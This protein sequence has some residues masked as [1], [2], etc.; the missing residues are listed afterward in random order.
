MV[1]TCIENS[2]VQ[3]LFTSEQRTKQQPR[4]SAIAFIWLYLHIPE[5]PIGQQ[6]G[7]A[8]QAVYVKTY[9]GIGSPLRNG[10]TEE[11]RTEMK[12][13]KVRVKEGSGNV[14]A[15]LG[16]PNP[17]RELL[18]A[19]LTLEIYRIIKN[20]GLTQAKAGAILGIKQPH[21]SSLMR[22]QSGNFSVERLMDFLTALGQDVEITVRPTRKER[23]D[24]SL[25]LA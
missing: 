7:R 11:G 5:N 23:G 13:N 12:K 24:V 18:K 14:F 3:E 2:G 19:R 25:V 1:R 20:R 16:F 15:D 21:V 9:T 4:K 8:F 10:T 17:D 6:A 22:G